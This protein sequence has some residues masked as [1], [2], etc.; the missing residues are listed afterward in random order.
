ME[1]HSPWTGSKIDKDLARGLS[2]SPRWLPYR[3]LWDDFNSS[4]Y[5]DIRE[6]PEYYLNRL[7]TDL[8]ERYAADIVTTSAA[9][10]LLEFGPGTG[11]KA[12]I[13]LRH[14]QR[15]GWFAPMD[16][17]PAA[18]AALGERV[19]RELSHVSVHPTC[20]DFTQPWST[21]LNRAPT[22]ILTA[23]MGGTLGNFLPNER[24][25]FLAN[26]A[27]SLR[28]GDTFVMGVPL[29]SAEDGMRN[30]YNDKAG[31]MVKFYRH[32]LHILNRDWGADFNEDAFAHDVVWSALHQRIEVGLRAR[33][34]QLVHV[35]GIQSPITFQ[36]GE[37]LRAVVAVRFTRN[38]IVDELTSHGLQLMLWFTDASDRYAV[39]LVCKRRL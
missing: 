23:L 13:L 27:H 6:Q 21:T 34:I 8:L 16:I 9:R 19:R 17:C 12:L 36:Q 32:C 1:R 28:A 30:A 14:M 29:V 4:V 25:R 7:E 3:L 2:D 26:L 11:E 33:T 37:V 15:P 35:P 24:H 38:R 39:A 10:G 5:D 18:L 22:P 31:F 20:A